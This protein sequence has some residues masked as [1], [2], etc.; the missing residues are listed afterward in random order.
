MKRKDMPSLG[1]IVAQRRES[2]DLSQVDLAWL[3]RVSRNTISNMERGQGAPAATTT[4]RV[5]CVL[6]GNRHDF[7]ALVRQAKGES[8]ALLIQKP[9]PDPDTLWVIEEKV[10]IAVLRLILSI[11]DSGWTLDAR[12]AA[13]NWRSLSEAMSDQQHY[14]GGDF[15]QAESRAS[16][17]VY[18]LQGYLLPYLGEYPGGNEEQKIIFDWFEDWGWSPED[19]L[20]RPDLTT[21]QPPVKTSPGQLLP[22]Q[23]KHAVRQAM[24]EWEQEQT[25]SVAGS[26]EAVAQ[27]LESNKQQLSAFQRLPLLVQDKLSKGHVLDYEVHQSDANLSHIVL[28]VSSTL[29]KVDREK[30][31]EAH[32]N[33]LMATVLGASIME[34]LARGEVTFET[35]Y[36]EITGAL[37]AFSKGKRNSTGNLDLGRFEA[38]KEL[39]GNGEAE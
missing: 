31:L 4:A 13:D 34:H 15:G 3:A 8:P 32:I 17:A 1:E 39:E 24:V 29:H 26:I 18:E 22:D 25:P 5:A 37:N 27:H 28:T 30:A 20:V 11:N 9:D 38:R 10:A 2:L 16:S 36:D 33:A 21:E 6:G 14:K 7:D 35:L 23:I 12:R 19:K